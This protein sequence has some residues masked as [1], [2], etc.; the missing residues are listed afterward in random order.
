M[1]F[2]AKT[3]TRYY[4]RMNKKVYGIVKSKGITKHK[5]RISASNLYNKYSIKGAFPEDPKECGNFLTYAYRSEKIFVNEPK[6][7]QIR[8][9]HMQK[10]R[11][12]LNKSLVR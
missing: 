4:K 6:I 12:A 2:R 3:I 8:K 7:M 5:N 11:S 1:D 10:I 9:R